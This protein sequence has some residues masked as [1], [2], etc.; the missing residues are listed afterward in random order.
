M[1]TACK[2][3]EADDLMNRAV[4]GNI[5]P[6]GA[7]LASMGG[8][9]RFFK[10][11]GVV[12]IFSRKQTDIATFFDLASL[13]KPLVTTAGIMELVKTYGFDI[14]QNVHCLLPGFKKNGVTARRLLT[15][16]SGLPP[17]RP[18]YIELSKMDWAKRKDALTQRLFD[19]PLVQKPG[20]VVLYSDLGFMILSRIIE[21]VSGMS[22][23]RFFYE[24]VCSPLGL[25]S[26][27]F[28]PE[29]FPDGHLEPDHRDFAATEICPWRKAM[30]KGAVHDDNAY[31]AGGVEGHAGL[32]GDAGGIHALLWEMLSVFSGRKKSV[33]F[34]RDIVKA[35]FKTA[36]DPARATGFDMPARTGASCGNYFS[37]NSVGH[38]GFTGV[39]FWMDPESEAIV[40]L[41][42]NRV[43]PSRDNERIRKFR[44]EIH[45]AV[46]KNMKKD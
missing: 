38:L 19:E 14:D 29:F 36:T 25:E 1:Q 28:V 26:L 20:E 44:P 24:T 33:V 3:K 39:S 42:T 17:W 18:Y 11:F 32:F 9:I 35:F 27:F 2:M 7:L 15:H 34:Q 46:M 45:D 41:L 22:L 31:A 30:L 12:D 40:I 6:G 10:A 23:D 4:S 16:T 43:H 5:F 8:D 21:A 13:T 37:K